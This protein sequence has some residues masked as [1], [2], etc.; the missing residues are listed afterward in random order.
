MD[1]GLRM[2][3]DIDRMRIMAKAFLCPDRKPS[4]DE[5][6]MAKMLVAGLTQVLDRLEYLEI[7]APW[8]DAYAAAFHEGM[9]ES[10]A[11]LM[12][13][14]ALDRAH[15]LPVHRSRLFYESNAPGSVARNAL[16]HTSPCSTPSD[17][18]A[19]RPKPTNT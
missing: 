7:A 8:V 11:R 3:I 16:P 6:G 10:T 4:K 12:A 18:G 1:A 19:T 9:D 15:N 5:L 2:P 17:P 14:H 13:M